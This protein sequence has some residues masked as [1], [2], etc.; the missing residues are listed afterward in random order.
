MIDRGGGV[1]AMARA[2]RE[3]G[4]VTQMDAPRLESWTR[5]PVNFKSLDPLTKTARLRETTGSQLPLK[6]LCGR[7]GCFFV[8]GMDVFAPVHGRGA[9]TWFDASLRLHELRRVVIR[10]FLDNPGTQPEI[11]PDEGWII[12]KSW[13]TVFGWIEGFLRSYGPLPV[14]DHSIA[15]ATFRLEP[16]LFRTT[17]SWRILVECFAAKKCPS[18][19]DVSVHVGAPFGA[20]KEKTSGDLRYPLEDT[21][22]KWAQRLPTDNPPGNGSRGPLD[23]TLAICHAANSLEPLAWLAEESGGYLIMPQVPNTPTR[24]SRD[25]L[26]F[27]ERT[28]VEL[29]ELD[30]SIARA[31]LDQKIEHAELTELQDEWKDV[32]EWMTGFVARW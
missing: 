6:W 10:A 17:P 31:L 3:G 1:R 13:S 8:P 28:M 14:P 29:A 2:M 4:I 11:S 7:A 27:W 5:E 18:K 26:Q 24:P 32:A 16:V 30:A 21:V 12:A 20:P 15:S 23:Y 19:E 22:G 25:L 9:R